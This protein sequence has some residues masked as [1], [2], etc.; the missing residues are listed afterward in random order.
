[1]RLL[2]IDPGIKTLG[3]A[4]FDEGWLTLAGVSRTKEKRI[5]AAA[6]EHLAN[7]FFLPGETPDH[8]VVERMTHRRKT[9][10][11][12]PQDLMDVNFVGGVV[13]AGWVSLGV[14][15]RA[16]TPAEW[17]GSVPREVEQKRTAAALSA[18]EKALLATVKPSHLA[19]N[20]WSAGG[21]GLAYLG[22]A[23][24]KSLTSVIL[25]K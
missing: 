23:H 20:A 1:M 19:H 3:W 2:A 17:K 21:I 14:Y 15:P 8:V 12:P 22:R 7:L 5:D 16:V 25:S 9:R 13:S 10:S 11:V 18:T 24:K 6:A 4:V